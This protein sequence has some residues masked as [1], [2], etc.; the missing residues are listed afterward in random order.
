MVNRSFDSSITQQLLVTKC[1]LVGSG[2]T[3]CA[4]VKCSNREFIRKDT[5]RH[6]KGVDDST[7]ENNR[8]SKEYKKNLAA[9]VFSLLKE[10]DLLG[11]K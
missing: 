6:E 8:S 2:C 11:K 4:I 5:R 3:L 10:K 1:C 9:P 7:P